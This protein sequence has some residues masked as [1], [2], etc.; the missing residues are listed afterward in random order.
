[1]T[2]KRKKISRPERART[3]EGSNG[4]SDLTF[5]SGWVRPVSNFIGQVINTW[6]PVQN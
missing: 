4:D 3:D 5:K 6:D 2:N 1:M